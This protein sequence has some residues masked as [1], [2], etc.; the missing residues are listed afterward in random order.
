MAKP[1]VIERPFRTCGGCVE[2]VAWLIPGGLHGCRVSDGGGRES[3]ARRGEV[4][5]GRSTGGDRDG[6]REGPNAEPR[7]RTFVLVGVAM[8]AA[9]PERGL[10]G[11]AGG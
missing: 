5:S 2:K 1:V 9:N 8:S 4:S 3:A 11:R 10:D 7:R 6:R